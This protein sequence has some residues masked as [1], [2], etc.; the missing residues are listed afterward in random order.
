MTIPP[1]TERL[2]FRRYEPSDLDAVI[3][4]FA[5]EE[6]KRWYPTKSRP[7][8]AKRWIDWNLANYEEHG[9]GLWVI[10]EKDT[11]TF[12]GDCGLTYQTVEGDQLLEVGYHLLAKH[13]G[14]GYAIE[15]AQG[16]ADLALRVMK[17]P[18]VCS[19]VDPRNQSSIRVAKTIH[20]SCR[21]FIKAEGK[22]WNLYWTDQVQS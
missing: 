4:M 7:E 17:S 21:S 15:S 3:E 5:D 10:E 11:G 18:M 8:E 13:R 16:C 9:V 1:P 6:A 2:R 20:E 14:K 22:E 12:V 19:I